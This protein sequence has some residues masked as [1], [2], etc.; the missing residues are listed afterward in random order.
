MEKCT[1]AKKVGGGWVPNP[2]HDPDEWAVGGYDLG[3]DRWEEPYEIG[4]FSDVDLHR[5]KCTQCGEIF[6]YSQKAKDGE[7]KND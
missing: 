7:V 1:H 5:Y 3:P 6:Y 4:T 2:Y